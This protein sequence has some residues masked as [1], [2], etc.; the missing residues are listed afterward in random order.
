MNRYRFR[1]RRTAKNPHKANGM[2]GSFHPA[3]KRFDTSYD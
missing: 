1:N 2:A 3:S